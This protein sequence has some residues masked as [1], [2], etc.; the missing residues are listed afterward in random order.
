MEEGQ[1]D[2]TL[3]Q[4]RK[5]TTFKKEHTQARTV[6]EEQIDHDFDSRLARE[7]AKQDL[8]IEQA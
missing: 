2:I 5:L 8:K 3:Q 4:S 7:R 1:I 6:K